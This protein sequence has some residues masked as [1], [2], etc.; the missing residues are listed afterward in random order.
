M[1]PRDAHPAALA[2]PPSQSAQADLGFARDADGAT[3]VSRQRVGY[4][5]HV[6]KAL[7][8]P[9]DPVGMPTVFL[10]S[11]SGGVFEGDDLRLQVV[12]HEGSRAHVST[13][14][15]T[16]V[17]SMEAHAATQKVEMQVH[18]GAYLEYLPDPLILFPRAK[19]ANGVDVR[20]H[21]GGTAIFS[22][23]ILLH[24]PKGGEGRFDWMASD[25]AIRDGGGRL[26]A[27]DRFRIGGAQLAQSRP[28]V[29]GHWKAQATLFVVT[30]A[31]PSADI[32]AAMR[33]ALAIEGVYAGA[34]ALPNQSGAW[35]RM[36]AIDAAA[37]KV[38]MFATWSAA[39]RQLTGSAPGPRRK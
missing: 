30:D 33:T 29:A 10:Q 7:K 36:L 14:A 37:L 26:L 25:T 22:D 18:A 35:T 38:G 13:A 17:H 3:Y 12:A 27:R 39:R 19:L 1:N 34:A 9:G 24:D 4:P 20:V 21:P 23:A 5:F 31:I 8:M 15:S 2:P 11:C 32:V 28:G 6:G 16:V